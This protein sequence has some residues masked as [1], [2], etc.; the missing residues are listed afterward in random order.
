MFLQ[1]EQIV[2]CFCDMSDV[3]EY[4]HIQSSSEMAFRQFVSLWVMNGATHRSRQ[5]TSNKS[6]DTP[7]VH[8]SCSWMSVNGAAGRRRMH[9]PNITMCIAYSLHRRRRL[10]TPAATTVSAARLANI[11]SSSSSDTAI[12][13]PRKCIHLVMTVN[14]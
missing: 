2:T 13:I 10:T 1:C 7:S 3:H 4:S 14:T 12:V 9:G 8:C 6:C 11:I 5:G